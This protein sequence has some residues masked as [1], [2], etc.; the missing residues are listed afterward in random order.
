MTPHLRTRDKLLYGPA[1]FGG[2]L[3]GVVGNTWLLY[4]FVNVAGLPPLL[5][6]LAFLAGRLFD[7]LVD[8]AIGALSDRLRVRRGRLWFTRVFALPAGLVFGALWLVPYVDGTPGRFLLACLGFMTLSVLY[9]LAT[10]PYLAL[11]PELTRDYD[12]RTRLNSYRLAFS[13]LATLVGVALPP[14]IV[15]GVTGARDLAS[16]PP[17]GWLVVGVVSA[18]AATAALLVTGLG[19]REPLRHLSGAAHPPL[20]W[21]AVRELLGTFGLGPLLG[22]FLLIT[23]ALMVTNSILPFFLESVLRLPG[24]LQAPLLGG[25]FAVAI[26]GFGLWSWLSGRIGKRAGVMLGS[27]LMVLSLLL[28]VYAVPRGGVSPLLIGTIVINGLGLAAVSLFPWA[29]LPDVLEFDELRSGLRREGLLYALLL[30]GLKA[31]GSLGVFSNALVTGGLGYVAGS[32][33][34]SSDTVRGIAL[35]MGP[36]PAALYLAALVCA[37]RYPITRQNHAQARAQLA[38]GAAASGPAD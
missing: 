21:R 32:A 2:N 30:L 26:L 12:E 9:S 20:R 28:Y 13:M 16:S 8:P 1:D 10:I 27:A 33:V 19:V 37:W 23:V 15:L 14:L 38:A 7:A 5:A 29:M 25:L 31:A 6:G 3:V 36:V 34:Q 11:G 4:Y 18:V 24:S 17:A 35:M 22:V